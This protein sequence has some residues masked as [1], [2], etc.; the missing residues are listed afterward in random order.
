MEILEIILN[1]K[2]YC[3]RYLALNFKQFHQL[4]IVHQDFHPGNILSNDFKN[5]YLYTSDFGLRKIV[6][7]NS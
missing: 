4:D 7:Q 2:L 5:N 6:G 3:L 1:N